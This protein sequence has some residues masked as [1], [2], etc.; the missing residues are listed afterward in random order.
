MFVDKDKSQFNRAER[1]MGDVKNGRARRGRYGRAHQFMR[2]AAKEGLDQPAFT[3]VG[4]WR[5]DDASIRGEPV[6]VPWITIDI[7]NVDLVQAHE[8]AV[9]TIKRLINLG[10]QEERII[11]SFSGGKGFH[12]QVD[13][14][15]MGLPPFKGPRHAR[16]F[17]RA[18]TKDVCAGS[19]YD[20]SV[21]APRSL[22]RV[23]GS[24]HSET[25]LHKRSFF[26]SAFLRKGMNGVMRNVREGYTPFMWP[27]PGTPLPRPRKHLREIYEHAESNYRGRRSN[28]AYGG[29]GEGNGVLSKI[30][31]GVRQGQEFGSR[32]FHVGRENAAFLMGCKLLEECDRKKTAYE[33]LCKWNGLNNPPLPLVR[34][35]AQWRGSKRKM[36]KKRQ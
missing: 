26:A 20:P 28:G 16:L 29:A 31:Y 6:Y 1:V 11:A 8:D 19:Y 21:C 17:L 3:N 35:K 4:R 15:Q 33:K 23:T 36:N 9:K 34:L 30:K 24:K 14:T 13:S 5:R 18:F 25:G 10:Y 7:D 32:S 12:V 22:I 27:E 2:W